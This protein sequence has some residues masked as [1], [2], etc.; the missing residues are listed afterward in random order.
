[1][2][3]A[4][5]ASRPARNPAPARLAAETLARAAEMLRVLAHPQR[6]RIVELLLESRHSVG[7]LAAAM[8]LA[9]AAVSGH[10]SHMRAQGIVGAQRDGRTVY[11]RVINPNA[12]NLIRCIRRHGS[13]GR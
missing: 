3:L 7:D 12:G 9:P 13:G 10:L 1:M 11:Y 2:A 5:P 4:T 6:L 8:D